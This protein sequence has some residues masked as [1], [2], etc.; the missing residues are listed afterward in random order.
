MLVCL[1]AFPRAPL[2]RPHSEAPTQF[3]L[4][5]RLFKLLG[6]VE[7]RKQKFESE[8]E[9]IFVDERVRLAKTRTGTEFVFLRVEEDFAD[10]LFRELGQMKMKPAAVTGGKVRPLRVHCWFFVDKCTAMVPL[11]C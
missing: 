5:E 3:E 11:E 7:V 4:P 1:F 10:M 2:Q 8:F 9:I 6:S